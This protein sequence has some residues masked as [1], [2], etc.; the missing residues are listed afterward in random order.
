MEMTEQE[1]QEA[2]YLRGSGLAKAELRRTI[3]AA[4]PEERIYMLQ[5]FTSKELTDEVDRRYALVG[6]TIEKICDAVDNAK[7]SLSDLQDAE[8]FIT[9]ITAVL[10]GVVK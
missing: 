10:R 4:D 3:K 6:D 2:R 8:A 7:D 9:A 5:F 1:K